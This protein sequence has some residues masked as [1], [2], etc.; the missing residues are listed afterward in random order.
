MTPWARGILSDVEELVLARHF[1][2]ALREVLVLLS[3]YPDSP[4][5]LAWAAEIAYLG[6][7]SDVTEPLTARE[8]CDPRL[9]PVFCSCDSPGCG[10]SWISFGQLRACPPQA[11]V[12]NARGVRCT[13]CE[14]YFC[15]NHYSISIAAFGA[16]VCPRCGGTADGAPKAPNGRTSSQTKR[17]NQPLIHVY[18]IREGP[19]SIGPAHVESILSAVSPDAFDGE[20]DVR[21]SSW[22]ENPWPAD[23]QQLEMFRIMKQNAAYLSDRYSMWFFPGTEPNGKNWMIIKVYANTAKYVDPDAP[24]GVA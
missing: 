15:R 8:L 17:L 1:R 22:T 5:A 9:D 12:A 16:A 23:P 7:R 6:A 21:I 13:R 14:G 3:V 11:T 24:Q 19:E 18:V 2:E 4:E 10:A 20:E